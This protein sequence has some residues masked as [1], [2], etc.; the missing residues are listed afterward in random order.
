MQMTRVMLTL[1]GLLA[2]ITLLMAV[3]GQAASG[4]EIT[5]SL[6][7]AGDLGYY[8]IGNDTM[9]AVRPDSPEDLRLRGM[10]GQAVKIVVEE[11]R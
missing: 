9:I 5:G 2:A 10:T 7:E 1:A 4:V 6:S 11:Q 3:V 8:A